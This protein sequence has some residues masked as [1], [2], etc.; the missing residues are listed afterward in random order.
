[1]QAHIDNN[2]RLKRINDLLKKDEIRLAIDQFNPKGILQ[3]VM[4]WGC[5]S[6]SARKIDSIA[7]LL[8]WGRRI[9]P[10]M[11]RASV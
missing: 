5:K 9:I 2:K 1:M 11:K 7:T 4:N 6:N 10:R 8:N 3:E